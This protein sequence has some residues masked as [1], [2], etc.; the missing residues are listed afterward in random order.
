MMGYEIEFNL[1]GRF[2]LFRTKPFLII[3]SG[4]KLKPL[5]AL[6]KDIMRRLERGKNAHVPPLPQ[7]DD[8]GSEAAK[9]VEM[10]QVRA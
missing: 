9:N 3:D 6:K 8:A 2:V 4:T 1:Y 10:P 5:E 7:S